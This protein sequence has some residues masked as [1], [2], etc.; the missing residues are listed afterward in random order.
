MAKFTKSEMKKSLLEGISLVEREG[1][2]TWVEFHELPEH[3]E[4]GFVLLNDEK[5][6]LYERM[7]DK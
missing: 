6:E 2:F 5:R 1:D 3:Y 4:H 7:K